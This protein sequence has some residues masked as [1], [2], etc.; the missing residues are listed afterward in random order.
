MTNDTILEPEKAKEEIQEKK[1]KVVKLKGKKEKKEIEKVN[2]MGV[3]SNLSNS[4]EKIAALTQRR[5]S[6]FPQVN[7]SSR[8]GIKRHSIL[9]SILTHTQRVS[10]IAEQMFDDLEDLHNLP[11]SC[12]KLLVSAALLHDIGFVR[13]RAGHH[14]ISEIMI[15]GRD[16]ELLADDFLTNEDL[17]VKIDMTLDSILGDHNPKEIK[18]IAA[19]ARYHRKAIPSLKHKNF[20]SLSKENQEWVVKLSALLRVADALDDSH[21]RDIRKVKVLSGKKIILQLIG[22]KA[23]WKNEI[24]A[25]KEKKVLFEN[26]YKRTLEC[27]IVPEAKKKEKKKG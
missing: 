8:P 19:I 3:K 9:S 11:N 10:A 17:R 18:I 4:D 21:R 2:E 20:K 26:V 13:G 12:K 6:D 24:I 16:I 23:K 1:A 5:A 27:Q 7:S 25:M 14:K 22:D 15:L